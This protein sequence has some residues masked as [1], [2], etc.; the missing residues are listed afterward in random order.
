MLTFGFRISS[1][2]GEVD[3]SRICT[4]ARTITSQWLT[5]IINGPSTKAQVAHRHSIIIRG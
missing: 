4:T 5:S 1:K 2:A 3:K